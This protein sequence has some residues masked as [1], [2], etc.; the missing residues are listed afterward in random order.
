MTLWNGRTPALALT[1]ALLCAAP[2]FAADAKKETKETYSFGTLRSL[3][4]A[5]ARDQAK[6]WLTDAGKY[7]AKA[8]DAIWNS[9]DR[10]LVDKLADTFVLGNEAAAKAM[11]LARNADAPPPENAPSILKDTKTPTF[12]RANLAVAYAKALAARNAYED[13]LAVLADKSI[14]KAEQTADPAAYFFNKAVCEHGLMMQPEATDTIARLLDDV[15]DVPERYK[16]VAALMHFDMLSWQ[17]KDLG[18]IARKMNIIKDRLQQTRGGEKTQKI[19]REVVVRLSE[20]IKEL[21]NKKKG[22]GSCNGGGCPSGGK[23]DGPNNMQPGNPLDDSRLGGISGAGIV[24]SKK[25]KEIAAVWGK[26]PEKERAKAMVELT[27]DLPPKYRDAIEAYLKG[28]SAD[29]R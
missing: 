28:I 22:G 7:D 26:L 6:K 21:E 15:A 23:Q 12:F 3:D 9:E 10:P 20:M 11:A 8:F 14:L 1:A 27:R 4:A 2:T 17:D 24:N 19:Q 16:M 29:K 5:A 13:A 25:F 18:W